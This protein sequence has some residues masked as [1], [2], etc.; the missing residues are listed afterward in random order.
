MQLRS[1]DEDTAVSVRRGA[2][3]ESQD[4]IFWEFARGID[5]LYSAALSRSC[6]N[7]AAGFGDE[8]AI[9]AV[10]LAIKAN[11]FSY[12]RPR[13]SFSIRIAPFLCI[14]LVSV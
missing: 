13:R 3:F 14:R 7:E 12:Y 1:A 6:D 10:G 9:R 2:K 4:E 8:A 5:L 11:G